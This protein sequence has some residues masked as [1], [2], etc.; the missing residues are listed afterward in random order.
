MIDTWGD[1]SVASAVHQQS[2]AVDGVR[3]MRVAASFKLRCN[4]KPHDAG[5]STPTGSFAR[6][7]LTDDYFL[8]TAS[9]ADIPPC[10]GKRNQV[11][12]LEMINKAQHATRW[13]MMMV[14]AQVVRYTCQGMQQRVL[15][16]LGSLQLHHEQLKALQEL[17]G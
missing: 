7:C 6:W 10:H 4:A 14:I 5:N 16:S 11:C 17:I 8:N 1:A 15:G 13:L 3:R 9:R 12:F 2:S